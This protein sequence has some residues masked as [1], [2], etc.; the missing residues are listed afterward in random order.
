MEYSI[1]MD[2]ILV[3]LIY[4]NWHILEPSRT[5]TCDTKCLKSIN[6]LAIYV[7]KQGRD[8]LIGGKAVI[9]ASRL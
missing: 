4:V 6:E 8:Y 3:L 5:Q 9:L 2:Q 1:V 7:L